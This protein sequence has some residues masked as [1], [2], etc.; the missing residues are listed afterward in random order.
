MTIKNDTPNLGLLTVQELRELIMQCS[1]LLIEKEETCRKTE[2]KRQEKLIKTM[3][4][5]VGLNVTVTFSRP[6]K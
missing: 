2:Q 5:T 3:A 1:V 6:R 4:K